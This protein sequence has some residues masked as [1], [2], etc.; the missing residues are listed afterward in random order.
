MY[1][2]ALIICS[3]VYTCLKKVQMV[4]NEH[5]DEGTDVAF[6]VVSFDASEHKT[7]VALDG[8][9]TGWGWGLGRHP[10]APTGEWPGAAATGGG[11]LPSPWGVRRGA[12]EGD[13][14]RPRLPGPHHRCARFLASPPGCGRGGA[15]IS[16]QCRLGGGVPDPPPSLPPLTFNAPFTRARATAPAQ[17]PTG[18]PGTFAWLRNP[19]VHPL[20]HPP[21]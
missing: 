5:A 13:G 7:Q 11:P 3:C 17:G 1:T 6:S 21:P 14:R 9:A 10:S 19:S 8:S 12:P 15:L 16:F 2:T 4:S 20:S 18:A